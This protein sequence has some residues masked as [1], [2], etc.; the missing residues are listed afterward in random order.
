MTT[1]TGAAA[2]A[3]QHP[4]R[5]PRRLL[6][7]VIIFGV[8][9]AVTL[10]AFLLLLRVVVDGLSQPQVDTPYL[11]KTI[12]FLGGVVLVNA[13]CRA[14]EFM[15]AETMGFEL[16]RR[17]RMTMYEHMQGMSARQLQGRA[18][19]GLL[20]RFTGD[21]SML[22]TWASR[23]I[24]RGLVSALVLA[25]GVTTVTV[26]NIRLGL[27][28][29][30]V[31]LLG[32]GLS[33][34]LGPRLRRIT[35]WVR[36][37]RSLLTSN[38]DEQISS[39]AVVQ[40]FGRASG[41]FNRLSRQNDSLTRSLFRTSAIRAQLLGVASV[42]GWLSIVA[43]LGVGTVEVVAGRSTVG[44][45]VVAAI[46]SRQLAG[47]VRRMGL[48]YD[49]WQRARV[50]RAK[51]IEFL[52]SSSR[53]LNARGLP[54]LRVRRGQI[55]IR[56]VS[57]ADAL[58]GVTGTVPGGHVVAIM[59]PT[60]AGKSTLLSVISGLEDADAGEVHVDGQPVAAHNLRSRLRQVGMV[61][62]DLPLMR[63]TVRRNLTYRK[64]TA[65]A[66]EI[67][68]IVLSCHLDEVLQAFPR[69]LETWLVE[70]A[71]NLSVG[72]RQRLALGRAL[73][74]NPQVLLLDEPTVNLDEA[75]KEVF[76]RVVS[77]HHGTILLVTHDPA[78]AALADE[79]WTM[80]AGRITNVAPGEAFRG[81]LW[82]EGRVSADAR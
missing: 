54:S 3:S 14:A 61:S 4:L 23:G 67:R 39:L 74:G 79:V 43:M 16:V 32:T 36:K 13:V 66:D 33:M 75:S 5:L 71:R 45:V 25:A 22:R 68:R 8:L 21:L 78:E 60:G 40:V 19:G 52:R 49:Y 30:S 7:F 81:S 11:F 47:P 6:S 44:I 38:I 20:L 1:H 80:D 15:A 34:E 51:V 63:G 59:G 12:A 76:W 42:T 65:T 9:Q 26:L 55:E 10:V 35:K 17:L 41:E 2:D 18:R 31:L 37:K 73:M 82:L 50:S 72:Q 70:G 64:P 69:G 29:L 77:H 28:M 62:P 24:G 48:S 53:P 56:D 27:I 57:V 46:A 58:S